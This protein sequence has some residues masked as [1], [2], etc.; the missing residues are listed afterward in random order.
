MGYEDTKIKIAPEIIFDAWLKQ[1]SS[2][3]DNRNSKEF[4]EL[5]EAD[6]FWRDVLAFSWENRTHSGHAEIETAFDKT[7][8]FAQAK[9][10][11]I[12]DGRQAPALVRRSARTVVE[13]YFE[14]DTSVGSGVGFVR[15]I[16]SS[17]DQGTFKIWHVL[18]SLHSIR[19]FEEKTGANRPSG[20]EF[21]QIVTSENW[22]Q[23][24]QAEQGYLTRD[25][26]VLIVGAAQ[27]GLMLGAR[28]RQMGVDVLLVD[29]NDQVGDVWRERYNN[30]TLHNEVEMN[31]FPYMSFPETWPR[32]VPKDMMASW[33]EYYAECM[34]LNIWTGTTLTDSSYNAKAGEWTVTLTRKDGSERTLKCTQ[35]VAAM[36]LSGGTPKK[37]DVLGIANFGGDVVHSGEFSTGANWAGKRAIVVGTGNSGHDIAQDLYVSGIESVSILQRGA[38]CVAS[39]DPSARVSYSIFNEGRNVDDIDLMVTSIPYP[40]LIDNYKWITKKTQELDKEL[41]ENLNKMGFRTH[42]GEDE[43]GF[44]LMYLRGAGGYYIDVGCCQMI[45]DGKIGVLQNEDMDCFTAE[46]LKKKDGTVIPCDLV[47]LA[48]GFESM[49][50]GIRNLFGDELADKVGPIWGFDEHDNMRN[51]WHRT[52][53]DGFWIMGGAIPE[54]RPNSRFLALEIKAALLG[55]LPRACHR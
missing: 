46:G 51:M 20:D 14:F 22:S 8:D 37:P 4:S 47:V 21:S 45:I 6:G 19:G 9:N 29:R 5:F 40:V 33:L 48:T 41:L 28:L 44:Q 11:R 26:E 49:H 25:P 17:S 38:T 16:P 7:V 31:H 13:G 42:Q 30:L 10:F 23:K 32:W 35:M 3:I 52:N 12:A 27:G 55:L 36:G 15:L 39:L 54:A 1:L 53:Q 34:E 43:T 18:T 2:A 50:A 24:R